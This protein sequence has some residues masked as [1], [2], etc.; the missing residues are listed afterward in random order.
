MVTWQTDLDPVLCERILAEYR[1]M[2][3]LRLTI[4]QAARL[5]TLDRYQ[6]RTTL[7]ALVVAGWLRRDS[8]GQYCLRTG[9][10]I[11]ATRQRTSRSRKVA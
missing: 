5:W 6:C 1:E 9:T 2:P 11:R 4:R 3:G 8:T 7:D 10:P